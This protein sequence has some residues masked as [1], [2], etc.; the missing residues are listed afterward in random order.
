M[1]EILLYIYFILLCMKGIALWLPL[2]AFL[3]SGIILLNG[4]SSEGTDLSNFTV[5]ANS[6]S[7]LVQANS[8][9]G[10][11]E[12]EKEEDEINATTPTD[13]K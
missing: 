2:G 10:L 7:G 3:I 8:T 4:Q 12:E 13:I 11:I 5:P 9:S 6:T 1:P